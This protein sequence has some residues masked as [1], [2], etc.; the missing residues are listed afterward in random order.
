M[1]TEKA[2]MKRTREV[3]LPALPGRMRHVPFPFRMTKRLLSILQSLPAILVGLFLIVASG[4]AKLIMIATGNPMAQS[5]FSTTGGIRFYV[6]IGIVEVLIGLLL[7]F[8]RT[9]TVGFVLAVGLLGGAM[10]TGLTTNIPGNW[11]WFP[12]VLIGLLMISAWYRSPELL[13][14][15]RGESPT[16]GI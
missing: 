2:R 7:L 16:K 3:R 1:R 5:M 6:V 8:R 14:R 9:F 12:L 4:G 10:A 11:P 13:S 15:L